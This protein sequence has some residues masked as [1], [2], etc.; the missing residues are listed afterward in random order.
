MYR[1][2]THDGLSP[3][4]EPG[5]VPVGIELRSYEARAGVEVDGVVLPVVRRP[6]EPNHRYYILASLASYSVSITS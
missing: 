2:L 4:P 5:P 3:A 1:Y 6:R